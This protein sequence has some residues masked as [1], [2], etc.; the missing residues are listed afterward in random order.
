MN[1]KGAGNIEFI[2]SFILF[3]SFV[4]SALYFFNP[5]KNVQTMEVSKEFIVNA[6]LKNASVEL[7][8][9]SV[10]VPS[11]GQ[12]D[13]ALGEP[14]KIARVEDY[15][16]NKIPS[17]RTGDGVCF[18]G[19]DF[20]VVHFSEDF[21]EGS[22]SCSGGS[23]EYTIASSLREEVIS[24]ARLLALNRTYYEAYADLKKGLD[25]P[26][27]MDFSFTLEFQNGQKVSAERGV[28]LRA[29]VFSETMLKE[30]IKTDGNSEFAYLTVKAW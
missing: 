27:G 15:Y 19:V 13:V 10:Y 25:I 1:R 18:G 9:Y 24:E 11:K 20:A 12:V 5:T 26:S 7:D 17:A 6:V 16:G 8:S 14:G 23:S 29:E 21:R 30:I 3:V 28:P 4:V 2:L 22:A